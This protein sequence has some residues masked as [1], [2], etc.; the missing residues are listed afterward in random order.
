M[1]LT[2]ILPVG[3]FYSWVEKS[4]FRRELASVHESHLIIAQNLSAALAR[5]AED[6]KSVFGL[7]VRNT[8]HPGVEGSY[9]RALANFHI[10]HV[11]II[12]SDGALET[13]IA[14]DN[15]HSRAAP[16][17]KLLAELRALAQAAGGDIVMSGIRPHSGSPHFFIVQALD[18]GRTAIAPVSPKYVIDLQQ[19]IAFGERGHSMVVDQNGHVVAH[20]NADWQRTSKDASALSVVQAMMQG[21]T[22]VMQFYSPPMQADMIAGYTSVA[23]TGWGVMVPQPVSELAERAH[24]M[25]SAA[26]V[27]AAVQLALAAALSWW[28][29]TWATRP[30]RAIAQAARQVSRGEK[31]ARVGRLPP[32]TP[33]EIVHT[34]KT[35]DA[36]AGVIERMKDKLQTGLEAAEETSRQRAG[37]LEAA[38]EANAVKSRFVSMVSHELRTPLTSIKGALDLLGTSAAGE[39]PQGAR[40]LID[41]ASRNGQRLSTMID[42]LLDLEKLDADKLRFEFV[43]LDLADLLTDAVEANAGYGTLANVRFDFDPPLARVPVRGDPDRLMQVM[44]NLLSNAA[45]FSPDGGHVAISLEITARRVRI[46][47][48]DHGV[49][50]PE[51]VG[52]KIFEAFEQADNSDARVAQGSGLGLSIARL[53]AE[54]HDGTLTYTSQ[55]GVG[56]V[57]TVDLPLARN[58]EGS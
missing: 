38:Q 55:I 7:A 48:R 29:S 54:R 34:A 30:I 16:A 17:P 47:V 52:D 31:G 37:M 25:Q 40:N 21:R 39:L 2:A 13:L 8:L 58:T 11:R 10:C 45:K 15:D 33:V 46:H 6:A 19:S 20:P 56:T 53:I 18:G 50:I 43:T 22:G 14:G 57:F 4:S 36:M 3:L 1:F 9:A 41:I 27:V 5:Y 44:A 51:R 24:A 49:G 28:L 26:W 35:F 32:L 23:G 12:G 42:D